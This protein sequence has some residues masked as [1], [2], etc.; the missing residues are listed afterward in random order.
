MSAGTRSLEFLFG[1]FWTGWRRVA[2]WSVC[3]IAIFLL[4]LLRIKTDTELTFSSVAL[5]P[6]LVIAWIDG[7]RNGLIVAFVGAAMWLVGDL[8]SAREFDA[9]W[10]PWANGLTRLITYSVAVLLVAQIRFQFEREHR[11]A[12]HDGLTGLQN[13]RAF[14][15]A[16]AAEVERAKRYGH[17][18]AVIFMDLD[19]FKQLNDSR[20]HDAGDA[21]LRAAATALLRALRSSDRVARIGGDEFA[22]LLPETGYEAAAEAGRKIFVAVNAAL[23]AFPPVRI[24]IGV[25]WF[26]QV[27]R[28]FPAML[29]AADGLMYEAKESGKHD[30]RSR[31]F[32]APE[33]GNS[34]DASGP[35]H[36]TADG[37]PFRPGHE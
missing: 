5:L 20:G 3:L 32:V 11:N 9:G 25:A 10:I 35:G 31:S 28:L 34:P 24:S 29:K 4:G 18:L 22:V 33:S 12:T 16:G 19:D 37:S 8:A 23:E 6:V 15:D 13:R 30:M 36:D 1:A 27:D 2:A 14:L 7:K 26:G 17:P 21:A